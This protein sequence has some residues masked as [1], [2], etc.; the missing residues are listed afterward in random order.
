MPTC[1]K[2]KFGRAVRRI[3]ALCVEFVTRESTAVSIS[4][5][6]YI[7]FEA[8]GQRSRGGTYKE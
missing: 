5:H 8:F 2:S 3:S 1:L 6:L 4:G 7:G